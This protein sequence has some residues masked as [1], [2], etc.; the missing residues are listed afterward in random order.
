MEWE[1]PK[2]VMEWEVSAMLLQ[3]EEGGLVACSRRGRGIGSL[4][5]EREGDW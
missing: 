2:L 5:K 3:G 4:F 1:W